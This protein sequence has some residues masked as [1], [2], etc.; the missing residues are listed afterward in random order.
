MF[1]TVGTVD[2]AKKRLTDEQRIQR[3]ISRN[4]KKRIAFIDKGM[5]RQIKD[6]FIEKFVLCETATKAALKYYYDRKG[7]PK[8]FTEID[9]NLS[10]VNS[11]LNDLQY[12]FDRELTKKM[13]KS[14]M[15]RGSRSAKDLRHRIVHSL[16]IKDIQE[17][18]DRKEELF[19]I[20]D[21][22][23]EIFDFDNK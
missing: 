3:Q 21:G 2:M 17:V 23:L 20:M 22:Y 10:S 13:F 8:K 1:N 16:S 9:L 6:E 18:V 12:S 15:K 7:T 19:K 5:N 11:A 4:V 14:K